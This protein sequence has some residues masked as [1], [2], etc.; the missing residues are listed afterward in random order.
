MESSEAGHD[1]IAKACSLSAATSNQRHIV[2]NHGRSIIVN[3]VKI[4]DPDLIGH[5]MLMYT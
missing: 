1:A 4:T 3:V 2:P 5:C